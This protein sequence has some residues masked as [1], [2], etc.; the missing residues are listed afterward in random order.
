MYPALRSEEGRL[1][2]RRDDGPKLC[3]L[4]GPLRPAVD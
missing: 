1:A 3:G 4:T 2:H